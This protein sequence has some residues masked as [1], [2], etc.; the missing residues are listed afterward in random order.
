[1]KPSPIIILPIL[2]I[3]LASCQS[4]ETR[5]NGTTHDDLASAYAKPAIHFS[6]VK[7]SCRIVSGE[8]VETMPA[9][10]L[11]RGKA[12]SASLTT[13]EEIY[14]TQFNFPEIPES[15]A[16]GAVGQTNS[17]PITPANPTAFDVTKLGWALD[18]QADPRMSFI[19]LRG[20]LTERRLGDKISSAGLP[21]RPITAGARDALGREVA[22]VLT[23]N[24][25]ERPTI[26][27]EEIP[28][29]IAAQPGESYRVYLDESRSSYAEFTCEIID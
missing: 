12:G 26:V 28:I 7:V 19:Q 6:K 22:V 9:T 23:E 27:T 20:K 1:M 15:E 8:T 5:L 10:I 14:P 25:A 21:F 11:K 13:S 3:A 24:R 18:L 29:L 4:N 17:F 2:S 16:F